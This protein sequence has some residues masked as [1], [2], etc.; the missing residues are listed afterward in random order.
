[1]SKTKSNYSEKLR[2]PR[3]QRRRLE[4]FQ[5]DNFTCQSCHSDSKTLNIHHLK[6]FPGREPW[7]YED[8]YLVT[9]CEK[10]HETEH[11]IGNDIRGILLE[12]I[13]ADE[14]Y[15]KPLAQINILIEKYPDFYPML[16][17]FLNDCMI[18]YL[19]TK[20]KRAA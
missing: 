8:H 10:C 4:I 14:I 18:Q 11:L 3:W 13:R 5:R 2:D 6:Y 9:Y 16:K 17:T 7:E 1:M 20:T 15:I 19:M 12:L